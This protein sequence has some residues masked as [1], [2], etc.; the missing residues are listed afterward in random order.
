[1]IK[2]VG[3][4][5]RLTTAGYV[6]PEPSRVQQENAERAEDL[7]YLILLVRCPAKYDRYL[8]DVIAPI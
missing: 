5:D 1:M 7:M 8:L 2:A 6:I 3:S 4:P